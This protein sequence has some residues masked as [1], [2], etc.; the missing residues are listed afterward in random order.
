M[1]ATDAPVAVKLVTTAVPTFAEAIEACVAV[2]VVMT[3][4]PT[5]A[6]AAR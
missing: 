3:P 4:T 6:E 5:L 2:S 1:D